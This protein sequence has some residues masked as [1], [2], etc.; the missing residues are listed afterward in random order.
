MA[1][2]RDG[3]TD[4]A[5]FAACQDVIGVV[6]GLCWKVEG[7]RQTGLTLCQ[8]GAVQL[9]GGLG[10]RVTRV[11]AHEPRLVALCARTRFGHGD[12]AKALWLHEAEKDSRRV[13]PRCLQGW[14]GAAYATGR[15][16]VSSLPNA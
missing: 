12:K 10:R 15:R 14:P 6:A 4:L 3:N 9:V 5:H 7:N 16:A 2:V 1:E 13:A 8:I 11:G